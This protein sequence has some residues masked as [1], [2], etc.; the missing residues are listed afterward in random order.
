MKKFLTIFIFAVCFSLT[1]IPTSVNAWITPNI[2]GASNSVDSEYGLPIVTPSDYIKAVKKPLR[3]GKVIPPS[4]GGTVAQ[5]FVLQQES[6]LDA[7]IGYDYDTATGQ[8]VANGGALKFFAN[9]VGTMI[10]NRPVS[11][12]DYVAYMDSKLHFPLSPTPAYASN[13]SYGYRGL[14]PLVPVWTL[15]RNVAYLL[16]ASLFVLTGIMIVLRVKIDP[17]TVISIQAALPKIF[18]SL[19]LVTFSYAIAGFFLDLMYLLMSLIINVFDSQNIA[20]GAPALLRNGIEGSVF[21][22]FAGVLLGN[23]LSPTIGSSSTVNSLV[24]GISGD[25]LQ[26]AI[27]FGSL[28]GINSMLGAA[29]SLI[30]LI[31]IIPLLWAVIKTWIM[32]LKSYVHIIFGVIISPL[33][34]A[35]GAL[36]GSGNTF[37]S[38]AKS[39]LAHILVFPFITLIILAGASIINGQWVNGS[40]FIAPY[41]GI[42]STDLARMFIGYAII[43]TMPSSITMMQDWLKTTG[44]KYGNEWQKAI[45]G[46]RAMAA[47][48]LEY[49]YQNYGVPAVART[50]AVAEVAKQR[51]GATTQKAW[52]AVS[53]RVQRVRGAG[54]SGGDSGA[55]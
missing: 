45:A 50:R 44:P 8:P 2:T 38:W 22:L 30:K 55:L 7:M 19:I 17:K 32:L 41:I 29:S 13:P 25:I 43:L 34:L 24:Q 51:V 16:F 46:G 18:F 4:L 40:G 33:W 3:E 20:G 35:M 15:A 10:T 6:M 5:S 52:N 37:A 39:I 1:F 48:G 42:Q 27:D 11:V 47:P 26:S 36:P 14:L 9:G 49:G 54:G 21:S 53:E 23:F 28:G 31:I 12:V